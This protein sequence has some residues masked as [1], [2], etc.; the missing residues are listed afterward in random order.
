[1]ALEL[2]LDEAIAERAGKRLSANR[3]EP[4]P[5]RERVRL[6]SARALVPG[7]GTLRIR[8]RG[9]LNDKLHGFYRSQYTDPAGKSHTL[10]TTQFEA[11]DARRAFPCW[12]EP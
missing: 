11:N 9:T 1:N 2:E 5:A 3:V 12:D 10:A 4:E 6:H 7:A 8:S